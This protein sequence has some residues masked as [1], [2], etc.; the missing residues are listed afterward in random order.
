MM[1]ESHTQGLT[2]VNNLAPYI[3]EGGSDIF[4]WYDLYSFY[5]CT[6][7]VWFSVTTV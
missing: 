1:E 2:S 7:F 6:N 4:Y 5:T 3:E